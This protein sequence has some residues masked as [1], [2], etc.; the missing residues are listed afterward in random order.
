MTSTDK[1]CLKWSE[2]DRNMINAIRENWTGGERNFSDM[3]LVCDDGEFA[4]HRFILSSSSA[5]FRS[6]LLRHTHPHP[7]L[8][9]R[10]VSRENLMNVLRCL[11]KTLMAGLLAVCRIAV[12]EPKSIYIHVLNNLSSFSWMIV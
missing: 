5:F 1:F 2:Y 9:I 8:Y 4:A 11:T 12:L 3:T 7:L 10:G 6:L